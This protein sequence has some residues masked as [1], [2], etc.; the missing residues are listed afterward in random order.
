MN[1]N[2]LYRS[3]LVAKQYEPDPR[4]EEVEATIEFVRGMGQMLI[5]EP[6]QSPHVRKSGVGHQYYTDRWRNTSA[7]PPRKK[8]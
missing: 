1:A 8:Q 6:Y 5:E 4:I 7:I 3:M 2:R